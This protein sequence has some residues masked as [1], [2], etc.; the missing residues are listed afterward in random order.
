MLDKLVNYQ[1][2]SPLLPNNE[3][4]TKMTDDDYEQFM[5]KWTESA[6]KA[7]YVKEAF[8]GKQSETSREKVHSLVDEIATKQATH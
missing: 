6:Q 4:L 7:P 3:T 5:D 2:L 8:W 1:D